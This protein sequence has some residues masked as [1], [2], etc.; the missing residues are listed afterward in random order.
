[1]RNLWFILVRPSLF[2]QCTS[3]SKKAIVGQKETT[4]DNLCRLAASTRKKSRPRETCF[5]II[6]CVV[7]VCINYA[8]VLK[9]ADRKAL[10]RHLFHRGESA[11]VNQRRLSFKENSTTCHTAAS[12]YSEAL[13]SSAAASAGFSSAGAASAWPPAAGSASDEVQS[14]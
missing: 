14:V 5:L 1:M 10:Q 8:G 7:L 9:E 12:I 2:H 11:V 6:C 3:G 13:D 4:S